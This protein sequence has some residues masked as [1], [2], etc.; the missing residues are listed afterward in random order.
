MCGTSQVSVICYRRGCISVI[1]TLYILHT[2]PAN[3]RTNREDW[4]LGLN[5]D[6]NQSYSPVFQF[7]KAPSIHS[8]MT[9]FQ[10]T[11]RSNSFSRS[12]VDSSCPNHQT[13]CWGTVERYKHTKTHTLGAHILHLSFSLSLSLRLSTCSRRPKIKYNTFYCL[14]SIRLLILS[15]K[16]R[17]SVCQLIA[18]RTRHELLMIM[19]SHALTEHLA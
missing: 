1:F 15:W 16:W 19:V 12:L 14:F 18:A 13:P 5:D 7:L 3:N 2:K 6:I 11:P 4:I 10:L 17:S 8:V 9:R